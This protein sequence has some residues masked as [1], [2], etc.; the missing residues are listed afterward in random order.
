MDDHTS[1]NGCEHE[2]YEDEYEYYDDIDEYHFEAH[3]ANGP[4]YPQS[5]SKQSHGCSSENDDYGNDDYGENYDAATDDY[6][7]CHDKACSASKP[8]EMV[9]FMCYW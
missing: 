3:T 2:E 4:E 5:Q 8:H 9:A 7:D 6:Y 1:N